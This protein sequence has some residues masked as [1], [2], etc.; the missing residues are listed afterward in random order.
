MQPRSRRGAESAVLAALRGDGG[1]A[2]GRGS[3][4][5]RG[6]EQTRLAAARLLAILHGDVR[7]AG[8]EQREEERGENEH[9]DGREDEMEERL[10]GEG[11]WR[12]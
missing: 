4:L 12:A 3:A 6:K 2:S 11:A 1:E 9:A 5:F 10:D 8:E 7:D